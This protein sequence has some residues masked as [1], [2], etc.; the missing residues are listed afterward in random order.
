M[1]QKFLSTSCPRDKS[2]TK[3][4]CLKRKGS[5]PKSLEQLSIFFSAHYDITSLFF[6][7]GTLFFTLTQEICNITCIMST[8]LHVSSYIIIKD[9]SSLFQVFREWKAVQSKESD[10]K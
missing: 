4:G 8:L 1:R 5:C 9:Y 10:E 7:S 2:Y 3:L 6:F